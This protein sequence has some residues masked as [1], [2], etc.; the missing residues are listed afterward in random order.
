FD[1]SRV[2]LSADFKPIFFEKGLHVFKDRL[3]VIDNEDV[4]VRYFN[5]HGFLLPEVVSPLNAGGEKR[6]A[7]VFKLGLKRQHVV[8]CPSCFSVSTIPAARYRVTRLIA[9]FSMKP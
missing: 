3:I 6:K 5:R 9:D 4:Y 8:S 1:A 2:T 7:S